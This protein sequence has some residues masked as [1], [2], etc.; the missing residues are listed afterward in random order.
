MKYILFLL[1][2]TIG[3]SHQKVTND[4]LPSWNDVAI[5]KSIIDY[6]QKVT[7]RES[8]DFVPV[9]DRIATFDNDGT[10]WAEHP[11][12]QIIYAL[13][14]AQEMGLKHKPLQKMNEKEIMELVA[15]THT[16]MT[17]DEFTEEVKEFFEEEKHPK[18]KVPYKK[19]IYQP[20]LEL[21]SYLKEN[22]FKV[23]ISSGGT[24]DFMRAI[25]EEYY[26]IPSEQV[27]GTSFKYHYDQVQNTMRIEPKADNTNDK[28]TKTYGIQK[29]IGKRPIFASGNVGNGGDVYMLRYSQGGR[30]PS[31][32]LLINHDDADREFSYGEKD[33]TSLNSARQYKWNVLS[34]KQDWKQVFPE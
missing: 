27:I 11:P 23:F 8:K 22:G 25:S 30:Y 4:P 31:Y 10:L 21:L 20:Q 28:I 15:K 26:G 2:L 34:I 12:V 16:G 1:I 3:C 32:Q 7:D 19:I 5:K 6:V 17:T 29:N 14:R 18:L 33:N 9:E 24:I 13:A